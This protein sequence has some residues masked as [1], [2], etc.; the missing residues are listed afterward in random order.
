MEYKLFDVDESL[1]ATYYE[2]ETRMKNIIINRT[3]WAE[4]FNTI[5]FSVD[6]GNKFIFESL[7]NHNQLSAEKEFLIILEDYKK[8]YS[9]LEFNNNVN[10]DIEKLQEF[11]SKIGKSNDCTGMNAYVKELNEYK[12]CLTHG[13]LWYSNI[14]FDGHILFYLD[15]EMVK[16]RIFFYDLIYYIVSEFSIRKNSVLIENYAKGIYDKAFSELFELAGTKYDSSKK[17]WYIELCYFILYSEKWEGTEYESNIDIVK[18]SLGVFD[19]Y[20]DN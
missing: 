7:Y 13:D 14:I 8:Y 12:T 5:P 10:I 19:Y 6:E 16:E 15:F 11:Y 18:R 9:I 2:D 1:I 20:G 17:R 3:K 4:F